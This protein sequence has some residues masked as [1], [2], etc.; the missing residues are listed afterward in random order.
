VL[1][2]SPAAFGADNVSF[3]GGERYAVELARAMA[4]RVPTKLLTFGA[5][6]KRGRE[7]PL[8]TRIARNWFNFRHF[9][10]DALNP[11]VVTEIAK[12]DI[13]HVHQTYTMMA[14]YSA[15]VARAMRK[16]VFT[17]D[18]GGFGLGF[19][20]IIDTQGWFTEHLHVSEFSRRL[21]GHENRVN[22]RVIYGG[23]DPD[24]FRPDPSTPRTGEVLIVSRLLP[25][26]GIDYLIEAIEGS[27]RLRVIGRP[28]AHVA[29][30]RKL[31]VER[32]AN[33]NVRFDEQ[34]T[35]AKLIRAYQGALCV[36]SASVHHSVFGAS[37]PNTELLGL[38][39]LEGMAC[40][41]PAIA[42]NVASLPELIDDG[43]TGFI[44]PPN[45]PI[46]LRERIV[47]LMD[48]PVEADL[49]GRAAREC[50]LRQFTWNAAVSECL[51]AYHA[52]RD[53]ATGSAPS[54]K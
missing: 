49:M 17:T 19:H 34:C 9:P 40:G 47:W 44:V 13:I 33:K 15:L 11:F 21:A 31:L 39:L 54:R 42:T 45:D 35:D 14:G 18:L 28:F 29:D 10:L 53:R 22:A 48:H 6:P 50:V 38:A 3:G 52:P 1:H 36:V 37:H 12:A 27:M 20:R 5:S 51:N 32:A 26:K 7:G 25:H 2:I 8:T 4:R 41:R 30:Y 16:P 46:A 24:R 43:V 23:I